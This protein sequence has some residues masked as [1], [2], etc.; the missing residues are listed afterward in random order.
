LKAY[1]MQKNSIH[2]VD[3]TILKPFLQDSLRSL[4]RLSYV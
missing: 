1:K 3:M 4:D 2:I